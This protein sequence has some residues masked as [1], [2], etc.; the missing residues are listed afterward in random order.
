MLPSSLYGYVDDYGQDHDGERDGDL[1]EGDCGDGKDEDG[2]GSADD[3]DDQGMGVIMM[4]MTIKTSCK[5]SNP[6][7]V[8]SVKVSHSSA[9]FHLVK[10]IMMRTFTQEVIMIMMRMIT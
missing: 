7:T 4:T 9:C 10:V 3:F 5:N 1:D 6:S 8:S 2:D